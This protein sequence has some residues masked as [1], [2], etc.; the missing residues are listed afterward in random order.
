MAGLK[1]EASKT[2]M[3]V[4]EVAIQGCTLDVYFDNLVG[5]GLFFKVIAA[6]L[7]DNVAS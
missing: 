4:V 5:S 2:V 3:S 1:A 7:D 6:V